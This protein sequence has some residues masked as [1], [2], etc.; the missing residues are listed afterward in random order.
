MQMA[1]KESVRDLINGEMTT[2]AFVL[3]RACE[4]EIMYLGPLFA[5]G[6]VRLS[7]DDAVSAVLVSITDAHLTEAMREKAKP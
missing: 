6:S 4:R 1:G 2:V 3:R 5:M 7:V